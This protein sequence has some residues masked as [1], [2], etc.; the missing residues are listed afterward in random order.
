MVAKGLM[1]SL[2]SYPY[3]APES[4]YRA[5]AGYPVRR[6]VSVQTSLFLEYWITRL[7]G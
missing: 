3:P 2:L 6:A 7:R 1:D 5:Y 4:S